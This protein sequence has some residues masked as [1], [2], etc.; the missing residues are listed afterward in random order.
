ME[1]WDLETLLDRKHR[2]GEKITNI[3]KYTDPIG[4]GN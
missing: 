2:F 4:L 1:T 3:I